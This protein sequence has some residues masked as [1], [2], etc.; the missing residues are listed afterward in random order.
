MKRVLRKSLF[1][2]CCIFLCACGQ[3]EQKEVTEEDSGT[4]SITFV[5]KSEDTSSLEWDNLEEQRNDSNFIVEDI[6]SPVDV[7]LCNAMNRKLSREK[8]SGASLFCLEEKTETIYFVNQNQDNYLYCIKE[9]IVEL[10]VE[11][12]VKEIYPY[13]GVVYFMLDSYGMYDLGEKK[14]GDIYKYIPET[15]E[16]VLVYPAGAIEGSENHK[17]TVKE[18]GIYFNYSETMGSENGL[19]KVKVSSYYLPFDSTE[20]VKDIEKL[21]KHGWNDY[22]FSYQFLT[23]D[24]SKLADLVLVNRTKG[25]KDVLSLGIDAFEYCVAGDVLYSTTLGSFVISLTNL[26]TQEVKKF[27]FSSG[28]FSAN[29]Y[30]EEEK[31]KVMGEGIEQIRSFTVTEDGNLL[32][33][34]D[35]EYLYQINRKAGNDI[36][37]P[38]ATA[39]GRR[40]IEELYTDGHDVYA[41]YASSPEETPKMVRFHTQEWPYVVKRQDGE[42]IFDIEYLVPEGGLQ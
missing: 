2:C 31:K 36:A 15:K 40:R 26:S 41:L 21:G 11:L 35:G 28:V 10:A 38:F 8:N 5:P 17:M 34:T 16:V 19:T 30:M 27:N 18:Q 25:T 6:K 12:P 29:I 37:I 24:K 1:L 20:P 3:A 39:D 4:L 22:Y 14:T 32:W 7:A 23:E 13:N 33:A 42:T 9:G